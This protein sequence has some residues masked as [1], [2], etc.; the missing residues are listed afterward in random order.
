MDLRVAAALQIIQLPGVLDGNQS[1]RTSLLL[2]AG[3]VAHGDVAAAQPGCGIL[4]AGCDRMSAT[5]GSNSVVESRLPKQP[6]P[7]PIKRFQGHSHP[8]TALI[9]VNS[10]P[11][12]IRCVVKMCS[13]KP[14]W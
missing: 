2:R 8:L 10:A 14:K 1:R 9:W 4:V 13:K 6:N 3:P 12:G 7:A 5:S 11:F